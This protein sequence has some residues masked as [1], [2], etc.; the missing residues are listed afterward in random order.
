MEG[1]REGLGSVWERG[2]G[3]MESGGGEGVMVG[4]VCENEILCSVGG[5][6]SG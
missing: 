5:D 4:D 2:E 1:G 3:L 6:V